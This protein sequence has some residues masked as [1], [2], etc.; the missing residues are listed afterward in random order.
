MNSYKSSTTG[1]SETRDNKVS[2]KAF[3]INKKQKMESSKGM[4]KTSSMST[5]P[6]FAGKE[7]MHISPEHKI[8]YSY[9]AGTSF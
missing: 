4:M 3:N 9:Q 7:P 5:L 6:L 1:I 2:L 8:R